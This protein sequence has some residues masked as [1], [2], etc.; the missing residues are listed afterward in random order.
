MLYLS[1]FDVDPEESLYV[2]RWIAEKH[3]PDLLAAG[4]LTAASYEEINGSGHTADI[5]EIPQIEIFKTPAYRATGSDEDD[6]ERPRALAAMTNR[7]N[8]TYRVCAE[9]GD[10]EAGGNSEVVTLIQFEASAT[11]PGGHQDTEFVTNLQEA[12]VSAMDS[13]PGL[14]ERVRVCERSGNHPDYPSDKPN[15]LI[16][17][18]WSEC[19]RGEDSTDLARKFHSAAGQLGFISGWSSRVLARARVQIAEASL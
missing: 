17:L 19:P 16:M 4:F 5:Y 6:P 2:R 9:H 7:S 8:T 11:S 18:E 1:C 13:F 3:L 12:C 10:M 14:L 15:W